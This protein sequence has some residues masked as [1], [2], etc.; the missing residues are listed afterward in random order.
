[1]RVILKGCPG[2]G[3]EAG[4]GVRRNLENST[5]CQKSMPITSSRGGCRAGFVV[6]LVAASNEYPLV[7]NEFLA[8]ASCSCSVS[9]TALQGLRF[10]GL[11]AAC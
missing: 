7:D 3:R 8:I 2:S 1:M 5:A 11:R 6:G 9:E 10:R 4:G